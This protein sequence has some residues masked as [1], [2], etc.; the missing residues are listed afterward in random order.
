MENQSSFQPTQNPFLDF[1]FLVRY[2]IFEVY[3][4]KKKNYIQ[5]RRE[6]EKKREDETKSGTRLVAGGDS[7]GT[8]DRQKRG[9]GGHVLRDRSA[10][11]AVR[12]PGPP[13]RRHF[14][15]RADAGRVRRVGQQEREKHGLGAN[16][17]R[18]DGGRSRS[19]R[20][21]VHGMQ[22]EPG[23]VVGTGALE[24]SVV[25]SLDLLVRAHRWRP[26]LVLHVQNHLRREEEQAGGACRRSCCV[27]QRGHPE[28]RGTR[29]FLLYI[30]SWFAIFFF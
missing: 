5:K 4:S 3:L 11:R 30:F 14:H 6:V 9:R 10:H 23:Q 19:R 29:F 25:P 12:H 17:I 7:G 1:S 8:V 13:S 27:E 18:I 26:S 20:R 2:V 21:P 22:H 24:Q 16:Q 15:R 28:G